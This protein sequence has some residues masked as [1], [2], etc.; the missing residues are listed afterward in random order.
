MICSA[1]VGTAKAFPIFE[2][3]ARST[4]IDPLIQPSMPG[5]EMRRRSTTSTPMPPATSTASCRSRQR[6]SPSPTSRRLRSPHCSRP[7]PPFSVATSELSL[8]PSKSG[9]VMVSFDTPP[10]DKVSDGA[11]G[12]ARD[13]VQGAPAEG[14][15][16]PRRDDAVPEPGDVSERGQ[17]WLRA[18]RHAVD[19]HNDLDQPLRRPGALLVVVCATGRALRS[20]RLRQSSTSFQSAASSRR[21]RSRRSS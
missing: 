6:S 19:A 7:A 3:V 4:F 10:G 13:L 14:R 2:P 5:A 11:F 9:D 16:P 8:G 18:Q 20:I 21:A 1:Q 12:A 15:D 17:L